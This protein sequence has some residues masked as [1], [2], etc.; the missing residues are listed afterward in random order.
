VTEPIRKR[1]FQVRVSGPMIICAGT[2]VFFSLF[3]KNFFS[4]S[5]AANIIRQA[6]VLAIVAFGQTF[7]IIIQGFDLSVGAVMGLTACVTALLMIQGMVPVVVVLILAL[8]VATFCGLINGV[9]TNYIGL[10]PFVATFGMWG[11]A[12]GVALVISEEKVVFG[13]PNTLRF[14]HDGEWL[15]IPVPLIL[16]MIIWVILH[17]FLKL[18]PY[19]TAT[20]A[21]GG[22]PTAAE[23]SGIPVRRYKTMVY[24]FSGL[25]AGIAGILFLARANAAQ[26]VDTI[27]YE[28]D[29][30]VAVVVGGTSLMGGKGGVA[31]TLLGVVLLA[32]VRNGLNMMGASIYLQLVA[33]GVILILAYIAENQASSLGGK[34]IRDLF[35]RKVGLKPGEKGS[36]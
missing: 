31:Q 25:M 22:N 14:L 15:G 17:L 11:M 23:L 19:G 12:L 9:V 3:A 5:N 7:A 33:V 20:Y 16:V 2:V 8:L 30:I 32:A 35:M 4:A 28:F 34:G 18:T 36:L 24:A 26:A 27:G 29:S 6:S 21:I 10:N 13:L 1:R